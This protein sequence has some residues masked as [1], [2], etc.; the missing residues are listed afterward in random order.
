[1]PLGNEDRSKV[2]A[3]RWID[4]IQSDGLAKQNRGA[5]QI[6]LGKREVSPALMRSATFVGASGRAVRN[7]SAAPFPIEIE[8]ELDFRA[9]TQRFRQVRLEGT[10]RAP[11]HRARWPHAYRKWLYLAPGIKAFPHM[12][13]SQT[14]PSQSEV[15]IEFD[16]PLVSY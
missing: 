3:G 11:R 14:G 6:S 5:L 2:G 12:G 7:V 4:R 16:G 13:L 15:G 8:S 10:G 9:N 1:M